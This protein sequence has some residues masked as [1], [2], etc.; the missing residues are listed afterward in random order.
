MT[1]FFAILA[2]ITLLLGAGCPKK[3][4]EPGTRTTARPDTA[5]MTEPAVQE[6]RPEMLS[7]PDPVYPD[8]AQRAGIEGRVIVEV[9]VDTTGAVSAAEVVE[10]SG[11]ARLDASARKAAL[12]AK[13]RP[14][15][16][17][18]VP[19]ESRTVIPFGF[20]GK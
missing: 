14:A 2:A 8:A 5:E 10:S 13:F 4:A 20:W 9:T 3:E 17:D 11:D 19:V 1:R 7:M 12:A 18:G 15:M 16:L 6:P